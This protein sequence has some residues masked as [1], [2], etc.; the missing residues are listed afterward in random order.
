[1]DNK[2]VP[3]KLVRLLILLWICLINVGGYFGILLTGPKRG[4]GFVIIPLFLVSIAAGVYF[5]VTL[6]KYFQE[7]T[8]YKSEHEVEEDNPE[9]V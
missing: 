5:K 9:I 1:M 8:G 7:M 6:V 4:A 3:G 2:M